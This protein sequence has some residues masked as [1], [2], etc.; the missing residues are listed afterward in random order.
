[1]KKA[2]RL[3]TSGLLL[4]VFWFEYFTFAIWHW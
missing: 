1:M 4:C 3:E 2:R